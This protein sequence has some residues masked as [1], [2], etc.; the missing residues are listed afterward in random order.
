MIKQYIAIILG[1]C[2]FWQILPAQES[3]F[4]STIMV[5]TTMEYDTAE[6]ISGVAKFQ[7]SGPMADTFRKD[8]DGTAK[9][10]F[11]NFAM[12]RFDGWI[13]QELQIK[14]KKE[15]GKPLN[16]AAQLKHTGL[17]QLGKNNASVPATL[18]YQPYLFSVDS[19]PEM[20][21]TE[22]L[23]FQTSFPEN[24]KSLGLPKRINVSPDNGECLFSFAPSAGAGNTRSLIKMGYQPGKK[25]CLE[26]LQENYTDL[27]STPFQL[28]MAKGN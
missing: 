13:V 28:L 15:T 9:I 23:L 8:A 14:N 16:F 3:K 6:G 12:D 1:L 19:L 22:L 25:D 7:I 5:S 27:S 11:M 10:Y 24:V 2:S 26:I 21:I 18:N 20:M 4:S 17:A